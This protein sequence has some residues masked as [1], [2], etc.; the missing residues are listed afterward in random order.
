MVLILA[1]GEEDQELWAKVWGEDLNTSGNQI[2]KQVEVL[3]ILTLWEEAWSG[4]L[5]V[6]FREDACEPLE[7]SWLDIFFSDKIGLCYEGKDTQGKLLPICFDNFIH[8]SQ[9]LYLVLA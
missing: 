4:Q 2:G 3:L 9:V 6:Q 1:A 8:I 5:I 7:H